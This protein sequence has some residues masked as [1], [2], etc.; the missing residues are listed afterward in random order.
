LIS[1][2]ASTSQVSALSE[3]FVAWDDAIREAERQ[4]AKLERDQAERRKLG[5]E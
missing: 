3:L 5:Y 2:F 4:V 1:E